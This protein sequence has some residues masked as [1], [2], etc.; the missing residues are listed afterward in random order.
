MSTI[1][2]IQAKV[3]VAADGL[4]GPKTRAAVAKALG[5]KADDRA[6]QGKVGVAS[7]GIIGTR[8]AAAIAAALG[9]EV[10]TGR[11]HVFIDIGHTADRAREYPSS[12]S[13]DV[14]RGERGL[15]IIQRLGFNPAVKDSLEHIMNTA[16]AGAVARHLEGLRVQVFDKP[17]MENDAE[18]SAVIA[19]ANAVRPRVFV[20]IHHNAQ[21]GKAWERMGG[22][23]SG[24]VVYHMAGRPSGRALAREVAECMDDFRHRNGMAGN[25]ADQVQEGSFAVIRKLD[26]QIAACLVEVGFYDNINDA[27][28]IAEHI[29]GIGAAIA[30]GVRAS[31]C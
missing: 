4:W 1:Q 28:F 13:P 16:I 2:N 3:G 5:C 25:R 8:S 26:P 14:W 23:A 24:H 31:L 20:S 11:V 22:T 7:D 29:E 9:V 18:I 15:G 17:A 12:F 19:E 30:E 10:S 21:G 27:A 6:I